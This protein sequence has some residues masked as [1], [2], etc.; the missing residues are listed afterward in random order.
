MDERVIWDAPEDDV[1]IDA[2]EAR[3]TWE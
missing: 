1:W 2:V 3:P